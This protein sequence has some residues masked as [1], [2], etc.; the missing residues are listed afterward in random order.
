MGMAQSHLQTNLQL[1]LV[2]VFPHL[3]L[4]LRE[5]LQA[6]HF[7]DWA[8]ISC[9]RGESVCSIYFNCSAT[10]V[11]NFKWYQARY[12]P[13][14]YGQEMSDKAR[15]WAHL[16]RRSGRFR[17]QYVAEW[18]DTIDVLL[19]FVRLTSHFQNRALKSLISSK[20]GLFSAVL[21][22]FVV[23]TS[24]SM[25][26]DYNQASAFL[27]SKSSR[28]RRRTVPKSLFL[29]LPPTTFP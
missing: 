4:E 7:L 9:I 8:R 17:R 3:T 13:D 11:F 26:P 24:Q 28:P 1:Q 25:Q 23:Q 18:R 6:A 19:V 15:I 27:L 12:P 10:M 21:T 22:T 20:A 14:P 29:P 16:Q 5:I 2:V